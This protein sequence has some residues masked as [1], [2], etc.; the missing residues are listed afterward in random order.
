MIDASFSASQERASVLAAIS[1]ALKHVSSL[2]VDGG[3]LAQVFA[4]N[5]AVPG[6]D[7]SLQTCK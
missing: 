6:A 4:T 2:Q 3:V 1:A 5:H 7:D